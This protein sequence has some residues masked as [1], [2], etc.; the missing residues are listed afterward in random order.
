MQTVKDKLHKL[1]VNPPA[2]AW[3]SIEKQLNAGKVIPLQHK[4][5][6][7]RRFY[8]L[9]AAAAIIILLLA[10]IFFKKNRNLSDEVATNTQTIPQG[11]DSLEKNKQMLESII[12]SSNPEELIAQKEYT[13]T[14]ITIEGPE[15]QPVK[16]SPKLA[17]FIVS[18]DEGH[19]PKPVWNQTINKWQHI[20]LTSTLS[21]NSANL[22]DIVQLAETSTD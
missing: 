16:I 11:E 12:N 14:Y 4:R 19:P 2:N 7:I 3:D 6:S 8:A 17:I 10:G 9:T 20:L 1:E 18:A 13:N 5:R 22:M 15:G 21:P